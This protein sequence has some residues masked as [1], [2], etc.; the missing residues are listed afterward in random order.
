MNFDD[1]AK[2]AVAK[3]E[4]YAYKSGGIV[5]TEHLLCGIIFAEDSSASKLLKANGI[6]VND[7][8]KII[9]LSGNSAQI[10]LSTRVE[11]ILLQANEYAETHNTQ[12][13]CELMLFAILQQT[14]SYAVNAL[15]NLGFTNIDGLITKIKQML[16]SNNFVDDN[17]FGEQ[18]SGFPKGFKISFSANNA[19]NPNDNGFNS[20]DFN[21]NEQNE[22]NEGNDDGGNIYKLE[23]LGVDLTEKA[24]QKKLDPVIGRSKEI[25]RIIQILSRR[26]KNNPVLIGEP[27]VGKSAVV[28]G[29]AQ[30]IVEGNVPEMLKN[31]KIFSL[32]MASVVAGT[33]YRG[34]FEQRLQSAIKQIQADGNII[35]F[36][37]EI[38]NIVG[39]GSAEGS[40]DAGNILKPMLARGELQTI[41]ATTI[42]EYRKHIEKDAALER[43]FQPIIVEPPTVEETITILNGLRNKYEAHHKVSITQGAIKAAAELS[44]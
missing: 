40:M 44:D 10:E 33:K 31:K 38:H 18:N 23:K 3:A 24:R 20:G 37:D 7:I 15:V 25:D 16:L 11:K 27:G 39:A 35:V 17:Q 19:F 26:T 1:I 12:I 14:N 43:R 22:N 5:G 21:G 13:S 6:T 4:E 42:N 8:P 32:D 30:A 28:E 2:I 9:R 29:L 36:I 34:E 41:G